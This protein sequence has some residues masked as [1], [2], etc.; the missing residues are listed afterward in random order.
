M[1]APLLV[2]GRP[3]LH[4]RR[5]Y[6]RHTGPDA[7]SLQLICPLADH[8]FG[9]LF[10][11]LA[12]QSSQ[13]ISQRSPHDPP[14]QIPLGKLD[15]R[16]G[17]AGGSPLIV[18]GQVSKSARLIW[19]HPHLFQLPRHPLDGIQAI[20][21]LSVLS[22]PPVAQRL[23][24][25]PPVP[26]THG[27]VVEI[28]L[29]PESERLRLFHVGGHHLL[30]FPQRLQDSRVMGLQ[31]LD[32]VACELR[33]HHGG[34]RRVREEIAEELRHPFLPDLR[35][36]VSWQTRG[37]SQGKQ[38]RVKA[39]G[40]VRGDRPTLGIRP[41]PQRHKVDPVADLVG[42]RLDV[43]R[44]AQPDD[45]R[46]GHHDAQGVLMTAPGDAKAQRDLQGADQVIPD[47]SHGDGPLIGRRLTHR[48]GTEGIDAIAD[49]VLL[50]IGGHHRVEV[51]SGL[52]RVHPG[53]DHFLDHG[54]HLPG[55]GV[56]IG[57]TEH[58]AII[59]P[60]HLHH[61][62]IGRLGEHAPRFIR[63]RLVSPDGS[64]VTEPIVHRKVDPGHLRIGELGRGNR[65]G[66]PWR[67]TLRITEH[68]PDRLRR[69]QWGH[70]DVDRDQALLRQH[71]VG[72]RMVPE[73]HI[74]SLMNPLPTLI[75]SCRLIQILETCVSQRS[76]H[77]LGR[78]WGATLA[79]RLGGHDLEPIPTLSRDQSVKD[80][81]ILQ[82]NVCRLQLRQILTGAA[83][84]AKL[85][86]KLIAQLIDAG[87]LDDPSSRPVVHDIVLGG[88]PDSQFMPSCTARPPPGLPG[89]AA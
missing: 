24:P 55:G 11:L 89:V 7:A 56:R 45:V 33:R 59:Q 84:M 42:Q 77:Q 85:A 87:D 74:G 1:L 15:V 54:S 53:I 43:L 50:L 46:T 60:K 64:T 80:D 69:I 70:V 2:L 48:P 5:A 8:V 27:G 9:K 86:I 25:I 20:E 65:E 71:K 57:G 16:F 68:G 63:R 17:F 44:V 37:L 73:A 83:G 13:N 31:M 36:R 22:A 67:I 39:T 35:L 19:R 23:D 58:P 10:L 30:R 29:G 76:G 41:A 66:I 75:T 82:R 78:C 14:I 38:L 51:C 6:R 21:Q 49:K 12:G 79:V 88:F 3:L 52:P 18:D 81:V 47:L 26:G 61:Q 62:I 32:Q 4:L 40:K 34:L 72:F 28:D